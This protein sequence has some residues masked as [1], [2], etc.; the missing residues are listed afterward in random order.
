M[1]GGLLGGVVGT[2]ATA[3]AQ[4]IVA[5]KASKKSRAFAERMS[6]TA[7]QRG[8]AD[9]RLAGLNPILAYKQG[10]ASSP[11]IQ[12]AQVPDISRH[13]SSALAGVKVD[14]EVNNLQAVESRDK[15]HTALNSKLTQKAEADRIAAIAQAQNTVTN[16]AKTALEIQMQAPN[17]SRAKQDERINQSWAGPGI[18]GLERLL[19]NIPGIGVFLGGRRG[20]RSFEKGKG[21]PSPERRRQSG[22]KGDRGNEQSARELRNF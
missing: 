3:T 18:M 4:G 22:Q 15:S 17:L 14:Q 6:N 19:K 12:A 16:S 2:A 10:G 9:M 21:K 13:L 7:Y 1:G 5:A 11:A 8:M 20:K